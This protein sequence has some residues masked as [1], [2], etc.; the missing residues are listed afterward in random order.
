VS[1]LHV[2]VEKKRS[3][4]LTYENGEY[5]YNYT[6]QDSSNYVSLTMPVR[7]K[8]YIHSKL[9]PI[10]E[11]HLPE[12]YLLSIVKKHFAKLH[13]TDDFGLLKLMS[14]SIKGRVTFQTHEKK[15]KDFLFLDDLLSPKNEN[16]F[17]EL[18]SRFALT[19]SLSGVQP[20]VVAKVEDKAT[21]K[22]ED[23][24]VLIY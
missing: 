6:S 16:L 23:Y 17:D 8:G 19:S 20:K 2:D 5:I 24:S 21:L 9:H 10:F 18:V 11:M 3:G 22:L 1:S 14:A 15:E 13:K 7:Q 12:G 4:I